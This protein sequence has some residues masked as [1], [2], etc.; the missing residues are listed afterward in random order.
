MLVTGGAG[1]LG[2][3]LCERLLVDGANVISVDN[4]FTGTR[5]SI[6]HLLSNPNFEIVRRDV[7]FS[8][9]IRTRAHK[10]MTVVS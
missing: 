2:S 4:D 8:L 6:E 9:L 1:F 10:S 5:H 7:T 3:H